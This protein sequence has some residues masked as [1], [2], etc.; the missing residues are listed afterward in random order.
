MNVGS[1]ASINS[2]TCNQIERCSVKA[3]NAEKVTKSNL[4]KLAGICNS[5]EKLSIYEV[6]E[7]KYHFGK[8]AEILEKQ[9]SKIKE[10]KATMLDQAYSSLKSKMPENALEET[11]QTK[12]VKKTIKETGEDLSTAISVLD[13]RIQYK[14]DSIE[15][16]IERI[17]NRKLKEE[18]KDYLIQNSSAYAER[19]LG[20]LPP[21]PQTSS[22]TDNNEKIA[23]PDLGGN[24]SLNYLINSLLKDEAKLQKAENTQRDNLEKDIG[25]EKDRFGNIIQLEKIEGVY[26]EKN[27]VLKDSHIKVIR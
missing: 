15:D 21:Q 18:V 4:K 6:A 10:K 9:G 17:P 3:Q 24:I 22:V 16:L 14:L 8:L 23:R 20:M 11:D 27:K 7:I 25:L 13:K 12:A 19:K 5:A 26:K 2:N 1:Y